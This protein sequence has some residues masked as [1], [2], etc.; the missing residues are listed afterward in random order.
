[1][2]RIAI[3]VSL[4]TS[5]ICSS[6]G[7]F[8]ALNNRKATFERYKDDEIEVVAFFSVDDLNDNFENDEDFIKKVDRLIEIKP[9]IVHVAVCLMKKMNTNSSV[10]YTL[11][12]VKNANIEIVVGTH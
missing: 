8:N 12:K 1:M 4:E 11:D 3:L 9:D 7:C 5:K 6:I 2:K 10:K